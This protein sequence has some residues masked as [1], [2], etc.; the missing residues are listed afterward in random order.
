[1]SYLKI[2]IAS[3]NAISSPGGTL[4]DV[5][6]VTF[7]FGWT[8]SPIDPISQLSAALSLL[9]VPQPAPPSPKFNSKILFWWGALNL[10]TRLSNFLLIAWN[11]IPLCRSA[12][13]SY[14]QK[15]IK[16]DCSTRGY[17]L[18]MQARVPYST[19]IFTY[20]SLDASVQKTF[21]IL[22]P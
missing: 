7:V 16:A 4:K 20:R 22:R 3:Q 12:R 19:P 18:Y 5:R 15:A 6:Y 1:M 11:N 9:I 2:L 21:Q 13:K 17:S 10:T 8:F 14:R